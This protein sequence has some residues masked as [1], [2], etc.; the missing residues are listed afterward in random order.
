MGSQ[1]LGVLEGRGFLADGC[2]GTDAGDDELAEQRGFQPLTALLEELRGERG[3]ASRTD[4]SP[5]ALYCLGRF[6]W[7]L[8]L[9]ARY[10]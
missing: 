8:A 4:R 5:R 10:E 7:A 3:G 1:G 6:R 9:W 2:F